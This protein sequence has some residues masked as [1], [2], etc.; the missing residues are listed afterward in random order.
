MSAYQLDLTAARRLEWLEETES[1]QS[2]LNLEKARPVVA[3]RIGI[4]PGTAEN[5]RRGRT[6]GVRGWVEQRITAAFIRGLEHEI[7][8]LQS[9]LDMARQGGT[10][11]DDDDF[12]AA[13]ASL[14]AARKLIGEV[15]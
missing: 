6:K 5:L 11:M 10:R 15:K 14:E 1:R 2:G 13:Q 8:R 4:L 9:E 12:L 7:R 3:S